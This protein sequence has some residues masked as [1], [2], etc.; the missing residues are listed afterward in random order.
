[1]YSRTVYSTPS[2][3]IVKRHGCVPAFERN[4]TLHPLA[5]RAIAESCVRRWKEGGRIL[6]IV[7]VTT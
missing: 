3:S 7:A 2:F 5:G 1:M 6:V 4:F